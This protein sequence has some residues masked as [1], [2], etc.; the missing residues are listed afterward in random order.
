MFADW[1]P[2]GEGQCYHSLS[3]QANKRAE[4]PKCVRDPILAGQVPPIT[5]DKLAGAS[6]PVRFGAAI[7]C[8]LPCNH[9]LPSACSVC[10]LPGRSS[11]LR[12]P[13]WCRVLLLEPT[14][15]STSAAVAS[16]PSRAFSLRGVPYRARARTRPSQISQSRRCLRP[17]DAAGGSAGSAGFVCALRP[18]IV[19][20]V[21]IVRASERASERPLP[22]LPRIIPASQSFEAIYVRRLPSSLGPRLALPPSALRCARSY[23]PRFPPA[24]HHSTSSHHHITHRP[25][26][27]TRRTSASPDVSRVH[28]PSA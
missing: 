14:P 21:S 26:H 25:T 7:G 8:Q 22:E 13:A 9:H 4:D 10:R 20:V 15:T 3:S 6:A 11:G 18:C 5:L 28:P 1:E 2:N 24:S 16:H 27:P 12:G 17:R 19:R 23:I